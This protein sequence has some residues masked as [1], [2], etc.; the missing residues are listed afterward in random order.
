MYLRAMQLFFNPFLLPVIICFMILAF[1]RK[2]CFFSF[3]TICRTP[4]IL[5]L[6]CALVMLVL[7]PYVLIFLCHLLFH[8]LV[9]NGPDIG[10][11]VKG[12][13]RNGEDIHEPDMLAFPKEWEQDEIKHSVVFCLFRLQRFGVC[14]FSEKFIFSTKAVQQ[15]T[16]LWTP[17]SE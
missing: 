3:Q 16:S 4:E 8:C 17:L 1:C 9:S 14:H 13:K 12:G 10:F 11:T 6:E 7:F 15:E 2:N 5:R